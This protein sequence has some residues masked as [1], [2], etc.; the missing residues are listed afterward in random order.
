MGKGENKEKFSP[1]NDGNCWDFEVFGVGI[2]GILV[3]F[4]G[5]EGWEFWRAF[6]G[7]FKGGFWGIPGLFSGGNSMEILEIPLGFFRNS[8][9]V[10]WGFHGGGRFW[11]FLGRF[12]R[13]SVGFLQEFQGDFGEIW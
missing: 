2:P 4:W 13:N 5:W 1:K 9:G 8:M 7:N 3:E 10:F 6:F 11:E 12:L